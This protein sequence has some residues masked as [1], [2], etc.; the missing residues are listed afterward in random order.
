MHLKYLNLENLSFFYKNK[1][2]TCNN[3]VIILGL[4]TL[5]W[6]WYFFF[7]GDKGLQIEYIHIKKNYRNTGA[8]NKI[9]KYTNL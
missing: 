2:L 3:I 7:N 1:S 8:L 9:H 6:F 4:Y 5:N